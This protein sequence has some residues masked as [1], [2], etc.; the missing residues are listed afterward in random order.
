MSVQVS[1]PGVYIEEFAP[2]AP[3]AGIGTN[4]AA[5]VGTALSGPIG[6]PQL[7]Q[8][9]DEFVAVFGGFATEAPD[10]YLAPAVYGFFLNG[11][12]TCYIIRAGVGVMAFANLPSRQSGGNPQP[13]L[14][15]TARVEGT[16]G[17][18]LSLQVIESSRLT[19]R[20]ARV[21]STATSLAVHLATEAVSA[22]SGTDA[23]DITVVSTTGF[24]PGDR[25]VFTLGGANPEPAVIDLVTA[26]DRLK[27]R[28]PLSGTNFDA[29][30][31][32]DLIAGQREFRVD[33][34]SG[35]LLSQAL[36]AG[37][38]I[39]LSLSTPAELRTVDSTS[40]DTIRI[41]Q[42]LGSTHALADP[43]NLPQVTSLEFNLVVTDTSTGDSET[44]TELSM[45]P[46]HPGYWKTAAL[47]TRIRLAV[48]PSPP[49]PTPADPRP[50]AG[51]FAL[52]GGTA[53]DRAAAWAGI[54]TNPNG[55]LDLFKPIVDISLVAI[56]GATDTATQQAVV[57][58]CE[59]LRNR[60]GILDS[61]M[62]AN[63]HDQIETQR[64]SVTSEL[65][66]VA[67]YYPW[68]VALNPKTGNND[69]WPPSGHIAGCYARTDAQRGVHKA[70]ANANIRG[71]LRLERL[72]TDEQQGRLNLRGIN[73]LRTF[74]GQGQPLVWG[75]RTTASNTNWQY[76][77]IRRLFIFLEGSIQQGIRGSVFEPN[78][79][80]LWQKLKRTIGAFL[81][82][83]W[84]DG[85]LF[86]ARVEDA[87][88]VRIDEVLNPDSE[89]AL[90]RLTIEIGVR[91]SYPAEFIIVR[92]GIWQGGSSVSES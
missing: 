12:T 84:R 54:R 38:L 66:Y 81:T 4:T 28:A 1:Y 34:P 39:S 30:R 22:V 48:P 50:N 56:P 57:A 3:I 92:I 24:A 13:A 27:L 16:A 20:L 62:D 79:T 37:S 73:V 86:G 46:I 78:N 18:A 7:V 58:H 44:F 42:A 25:V 69:T 55:Y 19:S 35:V 45:N 71:S 5:F 77:N 10:T 68:I 72:M 88:Y 51:T 67:L 33:V 41:A 11:G 52:S 87:F 47:S 61:V 89:R 75:A 9:W 63:P 21:N 65:G 85:A 43:T 2:A 91:P 82:Q 76:V 26:P 53:D 49:L 40:A 74:P 17:N 15:A 23:R 90:G 60:F 6:T 8:S 32:A 83:Q 70:P 29:V 59:G 14:V 80:S 31:S 36:P 64:E